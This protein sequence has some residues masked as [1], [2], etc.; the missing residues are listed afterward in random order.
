ML[1]V[2]VEQVAAALEQRSAVHRARYLAR[3]QHAAESE[4]R[5]RLGCSNLAHALAVEKLLGCEIPKRAQYLRVILTEL[6]RI[7][8]ICQG[9][10]TQSV[11]Q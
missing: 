8:C 2:V 9:S 3:L 1:H 6:S 7:V 4:P 10:R 5:L 11:A